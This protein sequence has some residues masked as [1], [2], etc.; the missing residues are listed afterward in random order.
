MSALPDRLLRRL[1]RRF[2]DVD[3]VAD[4]RPS[5]RDS[6]VLSWAVRESR[7]LV[8]EDYDFGDLV[9]VAR[10]RAEAIVIIAPGVLG[11]DLTESSDR[12]AERVFQLRDTLAGNLT[13][14]GRFRRGS[15]RSDFEMAERAGA[16]CDGNEM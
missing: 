14:M 4:V 13:I 9:F 11:I 2:D 6:D 15:A 3:Y 16:G 5:T 12:V 10:E 8:T 1:R 7:V